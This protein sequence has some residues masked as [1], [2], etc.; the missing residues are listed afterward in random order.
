VENRVQ[1][2]CLV[3][4]TAIATASALYWLRPVMIPFVLSVFIAL[5]LQRMIQLQVRRLRLPPPVA[6]LSTLVLG[7]ALL[8]LLASLVSA[9]V[10]Q[11]SE[12]ADVYA[13]QLR[14]LIQ[15]GV[16]A[17]PDGLL[18]D[19]APEE[20]LRSLT[21]VPVQSVGR[22]LMGTTNAIVDVLSKSLLV[23]IFVVFLLLGGGS[24][25][26]A[27]GV[28]RE[29][30]IRIQRFLV[31]KA[32]TSAATGLLV[33]LLLALLGVDLALVFGL[34]AFLL[35][36]IPSIGSIVATLLPLPVVLVNPEVSTTTAI[37]AL[38]LPGAVQMAIG[39]FVEPRIMGSSLDLH[40]V[41]ILMALIFWGMLW[42]IVGMLLATPITAVMKIL[43]ERFEGS[44]MLAELLAGRLDSLRSP[45]SAASGS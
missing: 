41:V 8:A 21:S 43:L 16:Q 31:T 42:G 12:N 45:G 17:L 18:A 28:W 22:M 6:M 9:S 7:I 33:G 36:F 29:A 10:T 30:E 19:S 25:R 4:L 5:T 11:L 40:P 1:T 23:L 39:N 35:N 20:A 34:F 26:E 37:L 38:L 15:R 24:M 14:K 27:T 44:R 13:A 3:I 2:S 32:L